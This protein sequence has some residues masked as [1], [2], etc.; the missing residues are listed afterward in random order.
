MTV[1]VAGQVCT[2]IVERRMI[3]RVERID[4]QLQTC[5]LM[6]GQTPRE[7][8]VKRDRSRTAIGVSGH[9]AQDGAGRRHECRRI[10]PEAVG[11][12]S[13]QPPKWLDLVWYLRIAGGI[14]LAPACGKVQRSAAVDKAEGADFPATGEPSSDAVLQ[15]R[16]L[17]PEG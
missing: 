2:R 10:V 6:N 15:V 3:E 14:Q 5:L 4:P 11:A 12:N 7:H 1:I 13:L 16:P 9:I 17:F 8:S